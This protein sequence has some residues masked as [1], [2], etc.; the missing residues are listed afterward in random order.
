[1]STQ[2]D[3]RSFPRAADDWRARAAAFATVAE[4]F[5]AWLDD[6]NTPLTPQAALG[7]VADLYAAGCKLIDPPNAATERLADDPGIEDAT[8]KAIFHRGAELPFSFYWLVLNQHEMD[9]DPEFGTGDLSDDLADIYRDL[10]GPLDL[11][12]T[13]DHASA[14]WH[15]HFGFHN[16]WGEH[17]TQAIHALHEHMTSGASTLDTPRE[18]DPIP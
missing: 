13:G 9:R 16:H 2:P 17:A 1:M 15:W 11:Y 6:R 14:V 10:V 5:V 7:H 4:C 8:W 18:S 3:E 12:R